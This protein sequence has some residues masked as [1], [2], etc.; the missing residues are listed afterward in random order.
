MVEIT[1]I[2]IFFAS[3]VILCMK[4]GESYIQ[5]LADVACK[6]DHTII[7]DNICRG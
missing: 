6:K 3:K 7:L 2:R 5:G 4:N 1:E